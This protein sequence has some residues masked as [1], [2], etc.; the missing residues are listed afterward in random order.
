MESSAEGSVTD[1]MRALKEGCQDAGQNL[2]NRYYHQMVALARRKLGHVNGR[3]ADEE[4]VAI[5]AFD[6]FCAGLQQGR[7]PEMQ[8][9]DDLWG[10]LITITLRKV[11]D[12]V[13]YDARQKRGGGG[14]VQLLTEESVLQ[15]L[16]SREPSPESSMVMADELDRLLSLLDDVDL[17]QLVLLKLEGHNNSESAEALGC[18]R[19]TVQRMLRLIRQTWEPEMPE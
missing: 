7:F 3:L 17:Q 11:I 18:A 13:Q 5:S 16:L 14:R 12:Q 19:V 10:M 8:D 9:R 15:D 4:D 2:W 6:S 1:I